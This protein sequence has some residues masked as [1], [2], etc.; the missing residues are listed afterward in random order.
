MSAALRN[1]R[2]TGCSQSTVL[3]Y[4]GNTLFTIIKLMSLCHDNTGK[5]KTVGQ[6]RL[7][8]VPETCKDRIPSGPEMLANML[9]LVEDPAPVLH[10]SPCRLSVGKWNMIR[11]QQKSRYRCVLCVSWVF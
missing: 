11:C 2:R 7:P 9:D 4:I 6:K 8:E 10:T 5:I 1:T 3:L